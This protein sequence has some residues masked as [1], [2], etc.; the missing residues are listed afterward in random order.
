M[1]MLCAT[2]IS[3][4]ENFL[5][6]L[7]NKSKPL[8]PGSC[9]TY[10]ALKQ[11]LNDIKSQENLRDLDHYRFNFVPL[12]K[13][14]EVLSKG[15]KFLCPSHFDLNSVTSSKSRRKVDCPASRKTL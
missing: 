10:N 8:P 2:Q 9:S 12:L 11:A 1:M 5:V 4:K 14:S 15:L 6:S 7:N 3:T 13:V